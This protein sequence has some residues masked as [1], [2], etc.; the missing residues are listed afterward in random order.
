[1]FII[2]VVILIIAGIIIHFFDGVS[3]FGKLPGDFHIKNKNF[4]FHF[5]LASS[6]LIS[7]I[8]SLII[9]LINKLR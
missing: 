6:I 2:I 9:Y 8:L 5:P 1:M 7:L 3:F 4:S